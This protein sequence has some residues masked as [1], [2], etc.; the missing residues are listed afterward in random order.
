MPKRRDIFD[1]YL[2]GDET[3]VRYTGGV[4]LNGRVL[5]A[6][7]RSN[8]LEEDMAGVGDV[9][10]EGQASRRHKKR[11]TGGAGSF[12]PMQPG[13][14]MSLYTVREGD[15]L[16]AYADPPNNSASSNV[17]A[18]AEDV[19]PIFKNFAGASKDRKYYVAGW[20]ISD[21]TPDKL[22]SYTARGKATITY[23]SQGSEKISP[24]QLVGWRMPTGLTEGEYRAELYPITDRDAVE[25]GAVVQAT[26]DAAAA[27]L[28]ND[29]ESNGNGISTVK[30]LVL[31][32][33]GDDKSLT[34]SLTL[35]KDHKDRDLCS[36]LKNDLEVV[37][38]IYFGNSFKNVRRCVELMTYLRVLADAKCLNQIRGRVDHVAYL[39]QLNGVFSA[40]ISEIEQSRVAYSHRNIVGKALGEAMPGDKFDIMLG[41]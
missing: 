21:G 36:A 34:D 23:N 38:N 14:A 35:L 11:K 25:I 7:D 18:E 33:C 9:Q 8:P 15:L 12:Y 10:R 20:A 37:R 39:S 16:M 3:K 4:I 17:S 27:A 28:R 30:E 2:Q 41:P 32:Y 26:H 22:V 1:P 13:S 6:H 40:A 19:P 31:T 5:A 24:N 29:A